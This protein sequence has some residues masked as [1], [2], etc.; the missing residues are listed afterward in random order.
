MRDWT[1]R[2]RRARLRRLGGVLLGWAT[3]AAVIVALHL[4]GRGALAAPRS[5]P[6]LVGRAGDDGAVTVAMALLR[7]VALTVAY[8]LVATSV[9]AGLGRLARWPA[10]LRLAE[11]ATLPPLRGTVRR[12]VGLGLAVSVTLSPP[13]SAAGGT[14]SRAAP[15]T[16]LAPAGTATL[17]PL[18]ST[19]GAWPP[20]AVVGGPAAGPATGS[21]AVQ[22][23]VAPDGTA[24]LRRLPSDPA[25][26]RSSAESVRAG[27]ALPAGDHLVVP[28]D[29]LW[30]LAAARVAELLG[31]VPSDEDVAPYW[32][33]VVAANAHLADPD[34]I[35]PGEPVHLPELTAPPDGPGPGAEAGTATMR[36]V[37]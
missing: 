2:H 25:L 11:A 26:A 3:V 35:F 22:R 16:A 4:L 36:V 21:V 28:G 6:E 12:L 20:A 23:L 15:V 31:G 24:T 1:M 9:L 13:S 33:A 19:P 32:R 10:L 34:L 8:H 37:P 30:A 7:L 18:P 14:P 5:L 27:P 17:R 29:H